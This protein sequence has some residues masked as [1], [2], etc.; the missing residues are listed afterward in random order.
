MPIERGALPY[1]PQPITGTLV[2]DSYILHVRKVGCN[3]CGTFTHTQELFEV[4]ICHARTDARVLRPYTQPLDKSL[5]VGVSN[6]QSRALPLCKNCAHS[7]DA[8]RFDSEK[9]WRE[10]LA[11]KA[12]EDSSRQATLVAARTKPSVHPLITNDLDTL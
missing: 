10:T 12:L 6:L 5:P 1:A 3:H 7:F 11:R 9:A 2:K 8:E 4:W